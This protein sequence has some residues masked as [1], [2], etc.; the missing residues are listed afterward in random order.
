[1]RTVNRFAFI[2]GIMNLILGGLSLFRPFVVHP[3]RRGLARITRRKDH[4]GPFNKGMG[5]LMGVMGAVNPPQA[6]MHT[7]LGAAG[8]ATRQYPGL[9]T[10]YAWLSAL[11]FLG[12]AALGWATVG[13]KPGNHN[14]MGIALDRKENFIHTLFG[15]TSLGMALMPLIQSRREMTQHDA[16]RM[17]EAGMDV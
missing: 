16:L 9:A 8:L 12:M 1:M 2:F 6:V 11:F 5:Q 7:T 4:V 3:P 10:P 14:V 13:M 15:I 17:V